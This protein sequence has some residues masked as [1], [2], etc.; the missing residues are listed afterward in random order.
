MQDELYEKEELEWF[1]SEEAK[2]YKMIVDW[3][4]N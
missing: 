2:K 4:E 3:F 1:L